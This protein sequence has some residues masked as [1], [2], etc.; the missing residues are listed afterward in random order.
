MVCS[1]WWGHFPACISGLFQ[2][3]PITQSQ[4]SFHVWVFVTASPYLVYTLSWLFVLLTTRSGELID[5][6]Q[7]KFISLCS[8][9]QE[10]P[11][12]STGRSGVWR[13]YGSGFRDVIFWL[14][15]CMAGGTGQLSEA[16]FVGTFTGVFSLDPF[17]S[18]KAPPTNTILALG[19]RMSLTDSRDIHSYHSRDLLCGQGSACGP[20]C[21]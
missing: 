2:L 6:P 8:G 20:Y 16:P 14:L 5:Y 10:D 15:P 1:W 19:V 21:V 3:L 4:R 9:G 12:G 7:Q 13:G 18:C 17:T 11:A